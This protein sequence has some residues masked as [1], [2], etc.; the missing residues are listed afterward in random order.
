LTKAASKFSPYLDIFPPNCEISPNL[1][2]SR[3]DFNLSDT[4]GE[5]VLCATCFGRVPGGKRLYIDSAPDVMIL[6]I[7]SPKKYGKY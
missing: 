5:I 4:I 2:H 1:A 7:F 3:Y 6:K